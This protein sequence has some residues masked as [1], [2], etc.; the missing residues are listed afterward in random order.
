MKEGRMLEFSYKNGS[1]RVKV[2]GHEYGFTY[3]AVMGDPPYPGDPVIV[4]IKE[5]NGVEYV[6]KVRRK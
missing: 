1:G 6:E 2:D 3:N 5:F 4:V